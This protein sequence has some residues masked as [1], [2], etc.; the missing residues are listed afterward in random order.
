MVERDHPVIQA[1]S[2]VRGL[3]FVDGRARQALDV[4]AQIISEQSRC[5]TLKRRQLWVGRDLVTSQTLGEGTERIGG[6]LFLA[7][8]GDAIATRLNPLKR[9][10]GY[11][12]IASE[13]SVWLSTVKK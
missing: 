3:K 9:I 12:G 11:E 6:K 5:P 8:K 4:V 2:H 10:G 13:S 1:D 7:G